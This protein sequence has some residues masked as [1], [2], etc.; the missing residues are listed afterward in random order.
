M[1]KIFLGLGSN[2]GDKKR[3]IL[4]AIELLKEKISGV[5][6][7]KLYETEPQYYKKQDTFMNTVL[8]GY[9]DES[10]RELLEFVKGVERQVGRRERFR[11]GP[12]E[13]DVDILFYDDQVYKDEKLTIPHPLLQEREFVLKPFMDLEPDFE[14]PVLKK[15]IRELCE[16]LFY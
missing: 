12:R 11:Y 8:S 14:H 1:I 2:L 9:T 16:E 5:I 3:N 10:P 15:T 6:V 13:V 7:A 4:D